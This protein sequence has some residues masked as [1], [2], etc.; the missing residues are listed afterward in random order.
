[1]T[2]KEISPRTT[3]LGFLVVILAGMSTGLGAA[4]VFFPRFVKLAT[5][6]VLAS[7]LGISG[8]VMVYV[9]FV[10][11]FYKSQLSFQEYLESQY[12][13]E[14]QRDGFATLYAT[15]SFFVGV[16]LN[17][18]SFAFCMFVCFCFS[19]DYFDILFHG[20]IH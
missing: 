2:I 17:C 3:G 7:S 14:E 6:R 12:D 1:M 5:R 15:L 11:I 18:V 19:F 10:E 8:G 4:V 9:S 20:L 13:D 16:A